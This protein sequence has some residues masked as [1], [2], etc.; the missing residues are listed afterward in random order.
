MLFT[1]ARPTPYDLRFSLLG[2]PVRI[3]PAFWIVSLFLGGDRSPQLAV[4]WIAAV[5]LSILVH[6][7]GHA[8][9]QRA[10]G[11]QPKVVLYGFGGVSI[12]EGVR[13]SPLKNILIAL[14][15]PL[16]GLALA[17]L[18]YAGVNLGGAPRSELPYVLVSDLLWINVVWSLLN[19][20][21]IW[22]LDGGHV[23]RE[24]LVLL[25]PPAHGILASILLSIACAIGVGVWLAQT[26]G[27][28]WN[29]MLFALLAYQNFEMLQSYRASRG[30]R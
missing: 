11:G 24:L 26:T 9:L 16:A 18:V 21:P 13:T 19:L 7:F 4:A 2:V 3:H 29:A 5:L 8:L 10:F 28:T 1:E 15:G 27:S 20:A 6:E 23:A 12:G 30:G 17:G 25:L 14:A 22:P